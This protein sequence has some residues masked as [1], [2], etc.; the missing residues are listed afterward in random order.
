MAAESLTA[1]RTR[2]GLQI[3]EIETRATRRKPVDISARMAAIRAC[4]SHMEEALDRGGDS[5][6]D[7]AAVRIH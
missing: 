4:L 5:E 3:A 1:V 6:R 7:A 2:I